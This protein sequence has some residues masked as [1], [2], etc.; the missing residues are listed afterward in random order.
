MGLDY[1]GLSRQIDS[2]IRLNVL[3][4][5]EDLES[6]VEGVVE[7]I[8]EALN[9]EKPRVI[10][11]VNEVNECG[12]FDAGLCST[13]MG[14]YVAN[15]PTIIINYRANLTTL[16]HLLAHHLQALEVGRDRY[17]QVR[18]AEELKLPW[19][20]RPLE[21]N[22]AVRSI[23]LAKG[24]PQRVFKVWN[25]EVRPVSKRIEEAVNK[26]RALMVHLSKGVESAIA[27]NWTY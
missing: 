5:L 25:E 13:V 18:D 26:V 4:N 7:I 2:M 27:N 19:D 3:R 8:T 22:A 6:S 10:A 11:T 23:R 16:L 14:L 21:V 15:N 24:I 20:V 17:V 9:V 1:G 12:R